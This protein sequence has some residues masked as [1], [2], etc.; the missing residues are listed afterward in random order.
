MYNLLSMKKI[1][2]WLLV[3]LSFVVLI[4][5][6]SAKAEEI[7]LGIKQ[8]SGISVFSTP[9]EALVFLDGKE[10]GKTPFEDKN[11]DVKQY[12]IK[13]DKDGASWQGNVKLT[14]GT[15]AIINRDLAKDQASSSGEVLTLDRG[16]GVTIVSNPNDA[17]IEIDGAKSGKT[18]SSIN[19]NPGEHTIVISHPNYLKRSIKASLPSNFNLTISVDLALSEVDLT[20]ISAPVITQ[21]LEVVVK[22]TPTGF[23]RVRDLASLSGKEI[24]KVNQGDRLILLEEQN[25]WDRIRLPDGREG[26]V[27]AAYVEKKIP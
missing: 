16:R 11:L 3:I 22:Q 17:E 15:M 20:T 13:L 19:L 7:L 18:P 27:S 25:G 23:L 21:T 12:T 14:S 5:R 10:V 26:F 4:V 24:A 6:Y 8:R 1:I 2:V 9:D